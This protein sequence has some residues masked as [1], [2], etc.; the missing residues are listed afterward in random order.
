V[1]LRAGDLAYLHVHPMG[2]E[3]AAESGPDIAF[4]AQVPSPGRYLLYLD[5]QVEGQVHTATFTVTAGR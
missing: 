1:A 5:F 2:D 4:M 3:P